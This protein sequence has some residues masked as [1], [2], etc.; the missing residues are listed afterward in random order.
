ML[1]ASI[2]TVI[3]E[4]CLAVERVR[5]LTI[6][7]FVCLIIVDV[8]MQ[9]C[10]VRGID[11]SEGDGRDQE[12]WVDGAWRQDWSGDDADLWSQEHR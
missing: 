8:T 12:D 4:A 1:N 3:A 2:L 10:V 9:G 7:T 5:I 11:L 6:L